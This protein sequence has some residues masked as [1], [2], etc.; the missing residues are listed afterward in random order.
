MSNKRNA[1][2]GRSQKRSGQTKNYDEVHGSEIEEGLKQ[3][4]VSGGNRTQSDEQME[5]GEG[6]NWEES[7]ESSDRE[8]EQDAD[9]RRCRQSLGREGTESYD[10]SVV[11]PSGSEFEVLLSDDE[12]RKEFYKT[13][14]SEGTCKELAEWIEWEDVSLNLLM[15]LWI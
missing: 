1:R 2:K 11:Y 9:K 10:D 5:G 7:D 15:L 13:W 6:N 14:A 12:N 3:G 4:G 8:N